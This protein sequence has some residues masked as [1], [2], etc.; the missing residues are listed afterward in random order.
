MLDS[1]M[2]GCQHSGPFLGTLN[3]R[4]R[5]IIG[6]QKK[7]QNF[8]NHPYGRT[9]VFEF[10]KPDLSYKLPKARYIPTNPCIR[11]MSV[12]F[13]GDS[14]QVIIVPRSQSGVVTF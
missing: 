7:D 13:G 14:I 3:I 6:I 5:I 2:G 8:D 10:P 11:G 1:H 4:C 12:F 9:S